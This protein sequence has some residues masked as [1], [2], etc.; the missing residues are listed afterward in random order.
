VVLA[1]V[2]SIFAGLCLSGLELPRDL[3]YVEPQATRSWAESLPDDNRYRLLGSDPQNLHVYNRQDG[4]LAISAHSGSQAGQ[5]IT[6]YW[7]QTKRPP[8][9]IN[10]EEEGRINGDFDAIK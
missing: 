9:N 10:P 5:S 3:P 7:D 8:V 6:R 1:F 2:G 4:I